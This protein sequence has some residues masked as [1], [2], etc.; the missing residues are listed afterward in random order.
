MTALSEMNPEK[1]LSVISLSHY[2]QSAIASPGFADFSVYTISQLNPEPDMTIRELQ[3]ADGES[4]DVQAIET[5]WVLFLED[6]E[7]LLRKEKEKLLDYCKRNERKITDLIIERYMTQDELKSYAWVTTREAFEYASRAT[8]RYLTSEA[9]LTPSSYLREIHFCRSSDHRKAGTFIV[10][11]RAA[12]N[13]HAL[14]HVIVSRKESV[15][16]DPQDNRK[17]K[18]RAIFKHGH[19]KYSDDTIYSPRF[20]WPHTVYNTIRLDH[21]PSVIEA[22]KAGLSNPDI[23]LFTLAYLIRF[24]NFSKASEVMNLIPDH[25]CERHPALLNIIAT[26]QF[27]NGNHEKSLSLFQHAL[28]LFPDLDWLAQNAIKFNL[29]LDRHETVDEILCSYKNAAGNEL[30]DDYLSHYRAIHEGL[31]GRTATISMCMV[32]KNEERTIE[33]AIISAKPMVDELIVI[34]TGSIDSS[35]AIAEGLGA[36]VYHYPWCDDFSAARNFAI[37]KASCDYIFMLDGDEYIPPFYFLECQT[38][39]KLLPLDKPRAFKLAIGKY[40]NETDWLFVVTEKGN[41]KRETEST[42]I[43]PRLDGMKYTGIIGETIDPF[44]LESGIPIQIMPG[45]LLHIIHGA[46]GRQERIERKCHIF[47]KMDHP[48]RSRILFAIKEFASIGKTDDTLRW[49]KYLFNNYG[50]ADTNMLKMSLHLARLLQAGDPLQAE[51]FYQ[52]LRKLYPDEKSVTFAY[53]DY[54]ITSNQIDK[55]Q[56][57][58]INQNNVGTEREPREQID[59]ECLKSLKHFEAGDLEDAL[60]ILTNILEDNS[61]HLFAQ[62]LRFYYLITMNEIEGAVLSLDTLFDMLR[63][64]KHSEIDSVQQMINAA[65]ELCATLLAG[66]YLKERSLVLHGIL[67]FGKQ[68]EQK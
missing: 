53:T 28:K 18:D 49:L 61:S 19:Q 62:S 14:P 8:R 25:W 41:F 40:S 47:T 20:G 59:L 56:Y 5:P 34:D 3:K 43:F 10:E 31:P 9:R 50:E 58:S 4:V 68:W 13:N 22:L 24:K 52:Q 67:T 39:K 46:E 45:S 29:L 2:A 11:M 65:E 55:I 63:S 6:G 7:F 36:H 33:R 17:P 12:H 16:A 42:R 26:L 64:R 60:H 51:Q 30:A 54:L 44:L 23:V 37:S 1:L 21:V 15:A 66:G 57:M 38:F 48:D 35:P 27:I 32:I